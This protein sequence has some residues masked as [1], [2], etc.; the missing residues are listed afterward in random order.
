MTELVPP[1]VRLPISG[2][3]LDTG[4][5]GSHDYVGPAS[6]RINARIPPADTE[7]V[8]RAGWAAH[9]FDGW[10][11]TPPAQR[12]ATSPQFVDLIEEHAADFASL[13]AMDNGTGVTTGAAFPP[14]AVEGTRYYASWAGNISEVI[15]GIPIQDGELSYTLLKPY[16]V[17]GSR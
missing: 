6:W 9:A 2:E 17:I 12:R 7:D 4:A 15:T 1:P 8:N 11:R 14:V 16:A 3:C 10:R 5:G 13:G